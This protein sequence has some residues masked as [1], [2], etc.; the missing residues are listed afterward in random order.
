MFN[1]LTCYGISIRSSEAKVCHAV[2]WPLIAVFTL[3]DPVLE[4]CLLTSALAQIT[5]TCPISPPALD[6]PSA[7]QILRGR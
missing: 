7:H 3:D 5:V 4:P 2:Q 1:Q 6:F